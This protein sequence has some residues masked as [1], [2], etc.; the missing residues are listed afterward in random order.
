MRRLVVLAAIVAA[1][2]LPSSVRADEPMP[3]GTILSGSG[4][5][6]V[7]PQ[8]DYGCVGAAA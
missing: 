5:T 3:T 4:E 1:V 8:V 6:P 2:L 7:S